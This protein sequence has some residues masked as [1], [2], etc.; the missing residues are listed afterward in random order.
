M[1]EEGYK[2]TDEEIQK[3]EGASI[4]E[5]INDVI[6]LIDE[7]Y[8]MIK[9]HREQTEKK[10][11]R[12]VSESDIIVKVNEAKMKLDLSTK[13]LEVKIEPVVQMISVIKTTEKEI[14]RI[15]GALEGRR[16][17]LKTRGSTGIWMSDSFFDIGISE[18]KENLES[19]VKKLQ[20]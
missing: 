2:P 4:T 8:S 18:V 16:E 19:I 10:E 17:D 7:V 12:T 13:A 15:E 20:K 1:S 9:M 11:T 5:D 14:H 6:K 3:A